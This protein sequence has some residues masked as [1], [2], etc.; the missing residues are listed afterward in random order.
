MYV[1]DHPSNTIDHPAPGPRTEL[2][3]DI[4]SSSSNQSVVQYEA[5]H[6]SHV[7]PIGR[8]LGSALKLMQ[9]HRRQFPNS[10]AKMGAS[11]E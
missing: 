10:P 3:G 2:A 8:D 1:G 5:S 4:D 7:V 9:E 11:Y 6:A